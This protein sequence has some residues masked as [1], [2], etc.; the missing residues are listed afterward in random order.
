MPERLV[1]APDP[2]DHT[3]EHFGN[4]KAPQNKE[5]QALQTQLLAAWGAAAQ[6]SESS[7]CL[8]QERK[9]TI[10]PLL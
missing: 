8:A 4:C 3:S 9:R 6:G 2:G 7:Q 10:K 5:T 1:A